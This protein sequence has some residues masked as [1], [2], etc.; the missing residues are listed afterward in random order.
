MFN[1]AEKAPRLIPATL[2]VCLGLVGCANAEQQET[3]PETTMNTSAPQIPTETMQ[4]LIT[5]HPNVQ[6]CSA[7]QMPKEL[8]STVDALT[9]ALQEKDTTAAEF[10]KEASDAMRNSL[11]ITTAVSKQLEDAG[12]GTT[13]LVQPEDSPRI[14]VQK[15]VNDSTVNMSTYAFEDDGA[16]V[17]DFCRTTA[18]TFTNHSA[19]V[20]MSYQIADG[21]VHTMDAQEGQ[22]SAIS[23]EA[24]A[25]A[26]VITLDL[27]N[28]VPAD[29]VF[30]VPDDYKNNLGIDV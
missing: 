18:T 15:L 22:F 23:P 4:T 14:V 2:V 20:T 1:Y 8:Q 9:Q 13:Q 3:A 11:V 6:P 21:K 29:G 5:K 28:L 26:T 24:L 25:I 30:N 10:Q 19:G 17:E 27:N 16:D 12:G 7:E